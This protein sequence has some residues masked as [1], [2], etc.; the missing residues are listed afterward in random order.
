MD[1]KDD[2]LPTRLGSDDDFYW[3]GFHGTWKGPTQSVV[4]AIFGG[5]VT[6]VSLGIGERGMSDPD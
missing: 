5:H 6:K 1:V 2:C 3:W 4:G